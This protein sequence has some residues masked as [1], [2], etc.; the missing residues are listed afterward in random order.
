MSVGKIAMW[1]G[2]AATVFLML[3]FRGDIRRYAKMKMM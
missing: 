2:I 3:N 1:S